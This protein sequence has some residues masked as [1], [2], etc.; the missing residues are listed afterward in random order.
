MKTIIRAARG[1]KRR[2][3]KVSEIQIPDIYN[4]AINI[5]V[6]RFDASSMTNKERKYIGGRIL[7]CWHLCHDLLDNLKGIK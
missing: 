1:S 2:E 7:E 5:Q 3:V 6:D 4:Y